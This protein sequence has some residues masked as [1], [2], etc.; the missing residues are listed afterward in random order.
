MLNGFSRET[1]PL[2]MDE[3]KWARIIGRTLLGKV[4]R[5]NAVTSTT[6][7]KGMKNMF[8]CSID[9]P[10]LRKIIH[11]LRITNAVPRLIATSDGYYIA[12]TRQELQNHIDS[13]IGRENSIRE[14]RECL[15][16]QL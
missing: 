13:L 8:G 5:S 4:G 3:M 7:I 12:E 14:V 2:S 11:H 1:A 15:Q 6:I 16:K 10:R 9:G